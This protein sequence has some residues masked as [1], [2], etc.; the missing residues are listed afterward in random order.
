MHISFTS[1]HTDCLINT[2]TVYAKTPI[3]DAVEADL[4]RLEELWETRKGTWLFGEHYSAADVFFAP[5]AAR[6]AGYDLPVSEHAHAYV[7]AHLHHLPFRQ[8]RA[9]GQTFASQSFYFRDYK[10]GEWLGLA[11]LEARAVDADAVESVNKNCPY[12]GNPVTDFLEMNGRIYVFC[13]PYYRD[14]TVLDPSSWPAF[15]ALVAT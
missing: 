10:I 14:K 3:S 5:V 12:S 13:N 6:I 15:V 1:L 11:P 7:E 8:F 4:R 2:R 9:W